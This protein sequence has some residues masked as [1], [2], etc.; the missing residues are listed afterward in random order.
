[1][2]R[3]AGGRCRQHGGAVR[4]RPSGN[5]SAAA[6]AARRAG[7]RQPAIRSIP[8]RPHPPSPLRPLMRGSPHEVITGTG[9]GSP[10]EGITGTGWGSGCRP[11]PPPSPLPPLTGTGCGSGCRRSRGPPAGG[12]RGP[13]GRHGHSWVGG[14][15]GG[16][17]GWVGLECYGEG[18]HQV[19]GGWRPRRRHQQCGCT[20]RAYAWR[21]RQDS[22]G[23]SVCAAGPA[24]S[25]AA[26]PEALALEPLVRL[27][28]LAAVGGS[29]G[30]S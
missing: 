1:M 2:G 18:M 14:W 12:R 20:S 29:S 27:V 15:V 6:A 13:P 24:A 22:K 23:H 4:G 10:H 5:A 7:Q 21:S 25:A 30:A 17:L 3:R 28:H 11:P 26:P 8:S 16:W 19:E 9:W